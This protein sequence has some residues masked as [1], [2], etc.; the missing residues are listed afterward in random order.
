MAERLA[1]S[2]C[3]CVIECSFLVSRGLGCKE[4]CHKA[5]DDGRWKTGIGTCHRADLSK[6]LVE[7]NE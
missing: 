6:S 2:T 1:T 3:I 4:S 5:N 7:L